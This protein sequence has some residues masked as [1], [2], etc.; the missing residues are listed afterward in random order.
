MTTLLTKLGSKTL[1]PHQVTAVTW[2]IN[3]EM[4]STGGLL[5]DEMG[6]GKT[7][8]VLGLIANNLVDKTLILC[9]LAVVAQWV[10]AASEI[11]LTVYTLTSLGWEGTGPITDSAI[12]ITNTDKIISRPYEFNSI[13]WGRVVIDEAHI[14]RNSKTNR[15]QLIN[16][17]NRAFTWCLTATPLVNKPSDVAALLHLVNSSIS[18]KSIDVDKLQDY[19]AEYALARSTSQ[20]RGRL[21]TLPSEPIT[22]TH[23]VDFA[24]EDERIFY[25]GVQ[26]LIQEQLMTALHDA[27]KNIGSILELILRLR[28]L[29]V[30]PQVYIE[31]RRRTLGST[32]YTRPD[33]TSSSIKVETLNNLINN[34]TETHGWVVFCQ[35]HDEIDIVKGILEKNKSIENIEIYH[36][37]MS[38]ESR[39]DAVRRTLDYKGDK[40]QVLLIQIHCGGTGLN[41]QHMDRVVFM[42]PWWTAALMDQAVGRVLRIGQKKQVVIH[43]IKLL[44]YESKNIDTMI[45]SKI[46]MKRELCNLML[47]SSLQT[48]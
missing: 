44:E 4:T 8:S 24:C 28:Q 2:M 9:P 17:L 20:L 11:G 12:Y 41:L 18:F 40:H 22:I 35:F 16:S 36:G 37:G 23:N 34:S 38:I 21:T 30:H 29:S 7:L 48:I 6:L 14:I 42:S 43:H 19:M 25:R 3:R 26:G 5:C 1:L 13:T 27:D 39:K 45:F 46:A 15:Y 33:W 47:G 10:D 32:M 31:S